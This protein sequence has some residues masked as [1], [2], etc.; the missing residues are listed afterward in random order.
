LSWQYVGRF[1][2]RCGE[3]DSIEI[4][5]L[6]RRAVIAFGVMRSSLV[7]FFP[8]EPASKLKRNETLA[9][10]SATTPMDPD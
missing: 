5:A 10:G 8:I 4:N 9:W 1:A 7:I 2:K 6:E 3:R